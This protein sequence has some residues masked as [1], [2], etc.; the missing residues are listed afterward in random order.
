MSAARRDGSSDHRTTVHLRCCYCGEEK[1]IELLE[2]WLRAPAELVFWREHARC[3]PVPVRDALEAGWG[4]PGVHAD[5]SDPV[6]PDTAPP[7]AELA[8]RSRRGP[9]QVEEEGK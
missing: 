9:A 7:P 4:Q 6:D 1:R 3:F 2:T 5:G 8:R